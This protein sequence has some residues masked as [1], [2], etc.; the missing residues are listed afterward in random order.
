MA[1]HD[2]N[3]EQEKK[4]GN[5]DPNRTQSSG[6]GS[7]TSQRSNEHE[8]NKSSGSQGSQSGSSGS[9]KTPGGS[10]RK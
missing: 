6:M 1:T 3:M 4:K 2:Q 10:E 5:Q 9:P 7:S 8:Q